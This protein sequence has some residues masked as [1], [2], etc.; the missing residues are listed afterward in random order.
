MGIVTPLRREPTSL[1]NAGYTLLTPEA[2]QAFAGLEGKF[3]ALKRIY[4]GPFASTLAADEI[5]RLCGELR[6]EAQ[7][8]ARL[9]R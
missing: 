3:N 1:S 6:V 5:E 2:R 8:V 4:S 9:A 7:R